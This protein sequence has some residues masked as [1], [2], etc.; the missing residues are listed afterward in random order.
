[1]DK[2]KLIESY[3]QPYVTLST[4]GHIL[5]DGFMDSGLRP[6]VPGKRIVGTAVT[7][8]MPTPD[9]TANRLAVTAAEAGDIIVVNCGNDQRYA[10]WGE[11]ICYDAFAKGISGLVIDGGISASGPIRKTGFQV[12]SRFATGLVG[13]RLGTSGQVG[14][15]V[16][17][18]N[19][20][21]RPGDL[22]F[23]DDDGVVVIPAADAEDVFDKMQKRYGDGRK[24][25][26]RQWIDSGRGYGDY[27]G[28]GWQERDDLPEPTRPP[29]V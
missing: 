24:D 27:P 7:A 22:I 11:M 10:R 9:S 13:R 2:Q 20:L 8:S 18:G 4:L 19:V 3:S 26:I 17:C 21:V 1:M 16:V 6:L 28:L 5:D 23:G 12:F 29:L 25:S 15:P 14:V